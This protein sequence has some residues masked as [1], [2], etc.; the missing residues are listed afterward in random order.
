MNNMNFVNVQIPIG[1]IIDPMLKEFTDKLALRNPSFTFGTRGMSEADKQNHSS[2]YPLCSKDGEVLDNGDRYLR[3][4]KVHCGSELLGSIAVATRYRRHSSNELVFAVKS[5][6]INNQRGDQH[7][8]YTAKLDNALRI[9]KTALAPQNVAELMNKSE[10]AV[11]RALSQTINDLKR[12]ITHGT[13]VR[14]HIPMQ[15]YLFHQLT[16][17]EIPMNIK[18]EVEQCFKS[19]KYATA[20]SEF[21]LAAYMEQESMKTVVAHNG[22]YLIRED[23]GDNTTVV[24]HYSFDELPE[25]YKNSISVLQ[26]MQDG[27]LVYDVGFKYNADNFSIIE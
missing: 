12:L 6:R 3:I 20:M 18:I 1:Y 7:V 21:E 19:D 10:D 5:W 4:L 15:Q 16:G 27:E 14:S 23:T 22:A 11:A 25:K 2:R 17:R 13:L 8:T 9:A 24:K 26:L